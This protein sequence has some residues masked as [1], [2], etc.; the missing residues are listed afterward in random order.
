MLLSI[1]EEI[2]E[3]GSLPQSDLQ[4]T[5]AEEFFGVP[6][7]ETSTASDS[8]FTDSIRRYTSFH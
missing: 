4:K 2:A 8:S 6:E 1:Q 5:L 3:N 7:E